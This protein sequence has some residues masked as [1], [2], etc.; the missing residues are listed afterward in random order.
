MIERKRDVF[1]VCGR[2]GTKGGIRFGNVSTSLAKISASNHLHV[3]MEK[4][5]GNSIRQLSSGALRA[6]D[7]LIS[8][9]ANAIS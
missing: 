6:N 1:L 8:S 2:G 3:E 9:Q 5:Y 4:V 7:S